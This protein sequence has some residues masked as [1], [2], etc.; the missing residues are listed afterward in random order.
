MRRRTWLRHCSSASLY[1]IETC[2]FWDKWGAD[3]SLTTASL[4]RHSSS[5]YAGPLTPAAAWLAC[6]VVSPPPRP[7]HCQC[8]LYPTRWA[9]RRGWR[10]RGAARSHQSFE[11]CHTTSLLTSTHP[12]TWQSSTS[13]CT[14]TQS[15]LA[16]QGEAPGARSGHGCTGRRS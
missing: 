8:G 14:A 16:G 2:T 1:E 3:A 11:L 12:P 15:E 10:Q 6:N 7:A 4:K 9:L 13:L 5:Y